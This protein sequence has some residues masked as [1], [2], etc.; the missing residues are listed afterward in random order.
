MS[1]FFKCAVC[2]IL[3]DVQGRC[4]CTSADTTNGPDQ[5]GEMDRHGPYMWPASAAL[6]RAEDAAFDYYAKR[7]PDEAEDLSPCDITTSGEIKIT[8]PGY[9]DYL[10]RNEM[11][12]ATETLL[13]ERGKTHGDFRDH[14]A[15]TMALKSAF[16]TSSKNNLSDVQKEAVHMILHKLG[17]IAAGNPDFQDHW[18]DIAGYAKLVSQDLRPGAAAVSAA[19]ERID[20]KQLARRLTDV[21]ARVLHY[22]DRGEPDLRLMTARE[23]NAEYAAL[24]EAIVQ[25]YRT[26]V[27]FNAQVNRAVAL[28]LDAIPK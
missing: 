5:G 20:R 23:V 3:P 11:P 7:R 27:R 12:D 6:C 10:R 19:E 26:D 24:P 2:K 15:T 8:N 16:F 1:A 28:I 9:A 21:M 25:R 4:K 18:D 13:A 14:A 17:R 22:Q